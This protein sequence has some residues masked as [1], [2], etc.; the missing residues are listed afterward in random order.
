MHVRP[1]PAV[2]AASAAVVLFAPSSPAVAPP[3]TF[4]RV[5]EA[6]YEAGASQRAYLMSTGDARGASFSVLD[7]SHHAVFSGSVGERTGSWSTGRTSSY[8]VYAVDFTAPAGTGYSI[9]VSGRAPSTSAFRPRCTSRC[10]GTRSS[11]TAASA[12]GR[13]SSPGR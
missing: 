2:L 13:A 8:G 12:T 3:T 5:D 4:V 10:S 11:T 9:A 1:L 6:G 7:A